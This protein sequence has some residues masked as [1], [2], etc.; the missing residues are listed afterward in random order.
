[1]NQFTWLDCPSVAKSV[2]DSS[3]MKIK[4]GAIRRCEGC[5]RDGR[6][7]IFLMRE[8]PWKEWVS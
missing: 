2:N 5:L 6:E 3:F 7:F 1:M 4:S 8:T